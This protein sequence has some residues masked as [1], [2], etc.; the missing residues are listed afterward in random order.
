MEMDINLGKGT[1]PGWRWE[2]RESE[3]N[4]D[5]GLSKKKCQRQ[6]FMGYEG[7]VQE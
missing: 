5:S 1:K 3:A 4:T 6:G 2:G 7:E